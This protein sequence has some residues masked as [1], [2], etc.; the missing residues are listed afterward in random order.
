MG[1]RL[2]A[3]V[4]LI[5]PLSACATRGDLQNLQD[6]MRRMQANQEI[7]LREIQRQNT[8]ILDSLQTQDIRLRG[9]LSN[10][11]IQI[12]RQ[13]VQIQEL[14]GQGQQ[15]LADLREAVRAR[16]QALQ[17]ITEPAPSADTGDA[18]EL[19]RS[20]EGA[21]QRGSLSTARA[22]FEEFVRSFPQHPLAPE[23]RLYLGAILN[24]EGNAQRALEEYQR[25][26]ELHP[27]APEAATALFRAAIVE[28]DRGNTARAR[29]MLNQLTAAYPASPEAAAARDELRGM[30]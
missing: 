8:A 30:R 27:T 7:L 22:G 12:E 9:G 13:L 1:R 11:L 23:A 21:L 15:G 14:T 6:E 25:I 24:Q 20:A 16:E 18:D 2:L 26:L 3:I 17:R 5:V 10:Q 4:A 19:F 29:T 28:R